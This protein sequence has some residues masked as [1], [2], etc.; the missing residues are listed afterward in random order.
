MA[1]FVILSRIAPGAMNDPKDFKSI[2]KKV[3]DKIKEECPNVTWKDS[4]A[5]A[6]RFD[7]CDI[8]EADDPKEVKRAAMVIRSYGYSTTETFAATPWEEFLDML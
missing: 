4:Y 1:T 2:A 5:L 7:V 3:S 8:V 6:G